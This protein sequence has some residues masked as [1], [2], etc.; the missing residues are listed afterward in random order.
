MPVGF[1]FIFY[2]IFERWVIMMENCKISSLLLV[3][4]KIISNHNHTQSE[5][6]VENNWIS[7][8]KHTR[9]ETKVLSISFSPL[10]QENRGLWKLAHSSPSQSP[11]WWLDIECLAYTHVTRFLPIS[12]FGHTNLLDRKTRKRKII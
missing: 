9:S 10:E 8:H 11:N 2:F 3:A 4:L 6:Q 1:I 5:I 7:N 12:E